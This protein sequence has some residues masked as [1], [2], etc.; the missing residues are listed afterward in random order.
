MSS[1]DNQPSM[2]AASLG[3]AGPELLS[4][5]LLLRPAPTATVAVIV[6]GVAAGA[7]F[8]FKD[9]V[10]SDATHGDIG[11]RGKVISV[12]A[13]ETTGTFRVLPDSF[14]KSPGSVLAQLHMP[15][16]E[17]QRLAEKLADGSVRLATVTVW[18]TVDEDG[19][20]VDLTAA[21][22]GQRLVIMHKPV[23]FL[24]P[25]QPGGSVVIRAVRD[26]GGGVTLGVSTILGPYRLP[27]LAVGQ[28]VEIP[29][30]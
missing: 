8:L 5:Q 6:I 23:T 7:A 2:D 28:S 15:E 17:K 3:S 25:V 1:N 10:G 11:D 12:A 21:G 4:P 16:A 27:A 26:G 9:R 19:D 20:T 29:A 24:V 22:F 14:Q 13:G 18:D 30:L